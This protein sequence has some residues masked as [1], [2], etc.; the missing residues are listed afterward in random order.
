[1]QSNALARLSR[2]L[3]AS[4]LG[5]LALP[6]ASWAE[7]EPDAADSAADVAPPLIAP[8]RTPRS[9]EG[10]QHWFGGAYLGRGLRLNNPYRLHRVLG[11]DAQS[12]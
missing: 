10:Y 4:L 1:M 6:S 5:L 8:A 12:L 3:R 11:S 7:P 2:A 9:S